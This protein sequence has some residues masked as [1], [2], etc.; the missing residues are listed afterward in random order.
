MKSNSY[1]LEFV[2]DEFKSDKILVLKAIAR[3]GDTLKN[4]SINLRPDKEVVIAAVTENGK[5][6]IIRQLR[7]IVRM[8]R[9]APKRNN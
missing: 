3:K 1:A 4:A 6:I 9:E 5:F 2:H 7:M 8:D